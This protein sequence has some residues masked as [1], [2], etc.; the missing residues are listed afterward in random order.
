MAQQRITDKRRQAVEELRVQGYTVREITDLLARPAEEGGLRNPRT[1]NPFRK[2]TIGRDVLWIEARWRELLDQSI[3]T[4]KSRE[5][6]E[7]RQA[8][9]EA[10]KQ[11]NLAEVRLNIAQE[12]KL[13]GTETPTR[14]EISGLGGNDLLIRVVYG[15]DGTDDSST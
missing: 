11:K 2:S 7:L 8:R 15:D 5:L 4:H 14:Q 10:W 9:L 12:A 6:R 13:L 1:G 3:Q